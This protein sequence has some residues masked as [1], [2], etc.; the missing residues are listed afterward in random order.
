VE[1]KKRASLLV[2]IEG[3]GLVDNSHDILRNLKVYEINNIT[4]KRILK[5]QQ[6]TR[7]TSACI[8]NNDLFITPN[9]DYFG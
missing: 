4:L 7:K 9:Y 3:K 8:N 1:I 5:E 2:P 6:V